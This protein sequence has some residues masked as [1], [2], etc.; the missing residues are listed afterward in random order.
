MKRTKFSE[1]HMVRVDSLMHRQELLHHTMN[2]VTTR[3]DWSSRI[4]VSYQGKRK[5]YEALGYATDSD[6]VF[7]YY[8]NKYDRDSIAAA[9]TPQRRG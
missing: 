5:L 8:W 2:A 1:A 4:G 9:V 3:L 6:L 7:S